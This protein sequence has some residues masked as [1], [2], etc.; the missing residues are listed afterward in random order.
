MSEVAG[1]YGYRSGAVRTVFQRESNG[2][3]LVSTYVITAQ[4][5]PT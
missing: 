5:L 2:T 4:L 1:G 3:R